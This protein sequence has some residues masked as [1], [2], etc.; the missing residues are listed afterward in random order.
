MTIGTGNAIATL[1][2]MKRQNTDFTGLMQR[3]VEDLRDNMLVVSGVRLLPRGQMVLDVA[4]QEL[5]VAYLDKT[6][7]VEDF[8][9]CARPESSE[10]AMNEARV[11]FVLENHEAAFIISVTPQARDDEQDALTFEDLADMIGEDENSQRIATE[12]ARKICRLVTGTIAGK[13]PPK[14]VIW[15]ANNTIYTVGEFRKAGPGE[16]NAQPRHASRA[17]SAAGRPRHSRPP[18]PQWLAGAAEVLAANAPEP[19]AAAAADTDILV[20]P[21]QAVMHEEAK[22]GD[23][24]QYTL[25][26]RSMVANDRPHLPLDQF[27]ELE[28]VKA[29]LREMTEEELA[30][31]RLLPKG[32]RLAIYGLSASLMVVSLPVGAAVMT[33]NLLGR[34][35]LRATARVTALA[36]TAKGL[37]M[38]FLGGELPL[39]I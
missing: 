26:L 23:G 36:A 29:V 34:E 4:G 11:G 32:Q 5:I 20:L 3:I 27:E 15:H 28:R 35:N 13:C 14:L 33:Y 17:Q 25:G 16:L 31:R 37:L 9:T 12:T 10:A 39:F 2:F 18:R 7:P 22:A 30:E 19:V 6:L 21:P 38:V 8:T 1:L 24:P